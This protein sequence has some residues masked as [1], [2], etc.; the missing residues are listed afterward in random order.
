MDCRLCQGLHSS[1][2][3]SAVS[4][5][6]P[7][8][9]HPQVTSSELFLRCELACM[10]GQASHGLDEIVVHTLK[11]QVGKYVVDRLGR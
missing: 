10:A 5:G 6:D 1:F 7:E 11:Q 8:P 9:A 4:Q 3:L 2:G